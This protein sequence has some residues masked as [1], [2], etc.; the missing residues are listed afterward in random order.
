M[1]GPLQGV[2][3]TELAGLGPA[4]F[5]GMVL[6]DLGAD[7]I[8]VDRIGGGGLFPNH[9]FDLHNRG[10]RSIAVD[11]K[12]EAGREIVLDL[13]RASDALIE[14]FRPGVMERLGLGPEVCQGANPRLVYTRITGFGQDGP[15]SKM[16]G[17]DIDYIA[18]SG[19]LGSIGGTD[20]PAIPLNL[21]ADFGGGGMLAAL[22][23]LAGVL[24]ARSTGQGQVID[25]AMIDGS[26]LLMTS[27]H[28]F[29]AEG[30]WSAQR[31]SNLLDGGAPFY[32]VYETSDGEHMAVGALEPQFFAALLEGL[33]IDPNEFP[34]QNDQSTWPAMRARFS[35]I[36]AG[37][38]RQQWADHFEGTDACVA[39]VMS[40]VEART[41][42]QVSARNTFVEV[43]GVSQ[44]APAPRFAVTPGDIAHGPS[45]PGSD[46]DDVLDWLG[47]SDAQIS[48]LRT[49]GAI[50]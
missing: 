42:P 32:S 25:S 48:K 3:V 30:W 21:I 49:S 41:H 34:S 17:H 29:E 7:V 46:T 23:V 2:T 47:Y 5:C 43:D 24:N 19:V 10:K 38:T 18:L 14:G 45:T 20:E 35:A 27:H 31:A 15:W 39:P 8:R 44:P 28:G 12:D 37:R 13:V 26:A 40:L 33:D 50:A 16:A 1:S 6:A 11:L 22:G 4:P 36:F 9:E